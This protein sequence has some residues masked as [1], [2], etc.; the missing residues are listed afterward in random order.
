MNA[1]DPAPR[2]RSLA[3]SG[4]VHPRPQAVTVPLFDGSLSF[5][6]PEDKVQVKYEMLRLHFVDG[7]TASHAARVHGYSRA[8]FYLI[9]ASF[10]ERGMLGL[11]DERR[12]R[13]GPLKVT[14]EIL[15]FVRAADQ[16]L[17]GAALAAAIE[18]RFG[19]RLHRRTVDRTRR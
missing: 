3:A 19:I 1:L 13:K 12:G 8:N 14:P 18:E 17:S 7:E 6:L 5:F 9:Q 4:L 15:A 10:E 2:K 11:L 16:E